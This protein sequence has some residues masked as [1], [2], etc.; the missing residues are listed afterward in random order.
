[1]RSVISERTR[2]RCGWLAWARCSV[3]VEH[4]LNTPA[5]LKAEVRPQRNL[6]CHWACLSACHSAMFDCSIVPSS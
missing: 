1:M 6:A 4:K 2:S 5:G 3:L